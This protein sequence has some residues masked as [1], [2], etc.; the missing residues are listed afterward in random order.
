MTINVYKTP[1][2]LLTKRIR[3]VV[4]G[5]GGTGSEMLDG[6]VKL[7]YA[8][9]QLGHPGGLHVTLFDDDVVSRTNVARQRFFQGDEGESKALLTIH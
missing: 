3:V 6:L 4:V 8:I 7:N 5:A 9:I 1:S 2:A